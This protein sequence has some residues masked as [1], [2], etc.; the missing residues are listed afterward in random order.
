MIRTDEKGFSWLAYPVFRGVSG[1]MCML[2]SLLLLSACSLEDDSGRIDVVGE[3]ANMAFTAPALLQARN[4][5]RQNLVVEITMDGQTFE[6]T[7]DQNGE[8]VLQTTRPANSSTMVMVVWSED[9]DGVRLPLAR[10]SKLLSAGSGS[11]SASLEFA[12]SEFDTSQDDFDNDGYSN[13]EERTS[14][15]AN[16]YAD[17]QDPDRPPVLVT[18]NVELALPQGMVNASAERRA[19]VDAAA[20]VNGISLP[21]SREGDLWRGTTTVTENT[22]PLVTVNFFDTTERLITIA[23]K[24]RNQDVGSGATARI[25]ADAYDTEEFNDDGDAFSNIVE[26]ANGTNPRDSNDPQPDGD[27][28]GIPDVDDNCPSTSNPDQADSDGDGRGN[29]CDQ[30]NELDPDN[31]GIN[32]SSDNCPN[33]ANSDQA[34]ADN[35]GVGDACDTTNDLD[36]DGDGV[37]NDVDNCPSV[38]NTDQRDTDGDGIG[39]LCDQSNALDVDNDGVNNDVDNC[40]LIDNQ[41][42]TDTDEDGVGDVCDNC[43]ELANTDQADSDGN[44]V[45]DVCDVPVTTGSTTGSETGRGL[46]Y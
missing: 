41:N 44:G 31:D 18:F 4:I 34:D 35:D 5:V 43:P 46:R 10:A 42:Q 2:A 8:Y 22:T 36:T 30:T 17:S 12:S 3:Q 45:G 38:A 15:S 37:N 20:E 6:G 24:A 28:D 13:Y 40:P 27:N 21:L 25:A 1:A 23:Y 7:P 29:V 32:G 26:I 11:S 19:E 16:S 9:I 39:D 33:I 14:G